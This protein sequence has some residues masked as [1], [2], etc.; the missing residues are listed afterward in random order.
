MQ[1]PGSKLS[2]AREVEEG[3]EEEHEARPGPRPEAAGPEEPPSP[4]TFE[5]ARRILVGVVQSVEDGANLV[6]AS[7]REE[8]S[9]FREDA[10]RTLVALA[11]L[12]V[13]GG[14]ATAGL[15]ILLRGWIGTWPPV[16]LVLGGVYSAA[17]VWL[18]ISRRA[19]GG[20]E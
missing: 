16:L 20:Y 15:A 13:G 7:V 4:S 3:K 19:S 5:L 1:G 6:G 2:E 8:L 11:F 18:L 9:R 12:A 17:G 10:V 14:L